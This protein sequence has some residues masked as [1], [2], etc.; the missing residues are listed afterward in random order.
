MCIYIYIFMYVYTYIRSPEVGV[1]RQR[2]E[3][4]YSI[5]YYTILP[6]IVS[7]LSIYLSIYLYVRHV[8]PP[9]PG[10]GRAPPARS[11]PRAAPGAWPHV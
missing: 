5:L 2:V 9:E 11:P 1:R 3:V 10:S 4:F 6:L 8:A 7:Y